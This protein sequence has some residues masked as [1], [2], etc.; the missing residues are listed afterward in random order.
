MAVIAVPG[1]DDT[2]EP[3]ETGISVQ[4]GD[5]VYVHSTGVLFLAQANSA[6]E[7]LV[8]GMVAEAGSVGA[9]VG[10]VTHGRVSLS[11][12]TSVVG[13]TTLTPGEKYYLDPT[14]PG[15]MTT[16]PPGAGS[17]QYLAPVGTAVGPQIFHFR[18]EHAIR[19]SA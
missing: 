3:V 11:D 17:G 18:T 16:S 13:S 4:P 6:P 9:S 12:W 15:N 10:V 8:F 14:T 7:A 19:R 1:L 2:K 5:L